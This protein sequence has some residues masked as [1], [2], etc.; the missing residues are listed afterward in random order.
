MVVGGSDLNDV[1]AYQAGPGQGPQDAEYLTRGQAAGLGRPCAWRVS[2]VQNVDVDREVDGLAGDA[3]AD[4]GGDAADADAFHVHCR[5]SLETQ[6]GIFVKVAARIDRPA[7]A[8]VHAV[9]F[10]EQ[11]LFG[12]PPKWRA[13]GERRAEV[14]VPRVNVGIEVDQGDLAEP[15]FRHLEQGIGDGVISAD[16]EQPARIAEQ[17]S[18]ACLDLLDGLLDIERVAGDIASVGDLL[19]AKRRYVQ[20]RV[21]RA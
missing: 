1:S 13:V 21:P 19:Y 10:Q 16:R 3:V 9:V 5:H 2:W 11:A 8:D 20:P 15:L 4:R 6:F 17:P 12:R 14:G 7:D 18:R